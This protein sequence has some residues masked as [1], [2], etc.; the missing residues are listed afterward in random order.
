MTAE[1]FAT[2]LER[3]IVRAR[4]GGLPDEALIAGLEEAINAI[5]EDM[6]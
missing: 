6:D 3:L 1:E 2:E 4:S 5:E